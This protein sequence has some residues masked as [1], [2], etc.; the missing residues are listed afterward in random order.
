MQKRKNNMID[1]F[2]LWVFVKISKLWFNAVIFGAD[3]ETER[4][5]S[6]SF[7]VDE[8]HANYFMEVLA[9]GREGVKK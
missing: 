6:I 4:T 2:L 9:R 3:P 1:T 8:E 5:S 7:F